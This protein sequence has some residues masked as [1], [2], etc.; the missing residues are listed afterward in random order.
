LQNLNPRTPMSTLMTSAT[1]KVFVPTFQAM[2]TFV[3]WNSREVKQLNPL[4]I[5][6]FPFAWLA[7]VI[8]KLVLPFLATA[9][10]KHANTTSDSLKL[11][12]AEHLAARL[13]QQVAPRVDGDAATVEAQRNAV[14]ALFAYLP[15]ATRYQVEGAIYN[16]LANTGEAGLENPLFG[17][18]FRE[19]NQRHPVIRTALLDVLAS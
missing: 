14:D 6:S 4:A 12:V 19:N 1:D 11:K 13:P 18:V 9:M 3:T 10:L 16:R 7:Q 5:A 2:D 17:Q 15:V 8:N